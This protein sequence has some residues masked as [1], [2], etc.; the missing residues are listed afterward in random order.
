MTRLVLACNYENTSNDYQIR[1]ADKETLK[2][3]ES[4]IIAGAKQLSPG[5]NIMIFTGDDS[6]IKSKVLELYDYT[7]EEL[8]TLLKGD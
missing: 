2:L 8:D 6:T 7:P 5:I 1:V 3:L 4:Y